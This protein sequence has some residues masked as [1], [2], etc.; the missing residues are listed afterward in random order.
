MEGVRLYVDG[1]ESG[2]ELGELHLPHSL[3]QLG[4]HA[5]VVTPQSTRGNERR[6][7]LDELR[8]FSKALT[9][10]AVQSLSELGSGRAGAMPSIAVQNPNAWNRHW[11]A[12]FGWTGDRPVPRLGPSTVLL[13]AGELGPEKAAPPSRVSFRLLPAAEALNVGGLSRTQI[14]TLY[15]V[16]TRL[17]R[18]YLPLDQPAWVGVPPE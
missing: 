8:V 6:V 3:D 11:K 17:L 9:E 1:H 14:A 5:E 4:F 10:I 13:R 7:F 18:R 2:R 16:K 12:R 15:G